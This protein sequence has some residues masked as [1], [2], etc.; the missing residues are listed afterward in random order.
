MGALLDVMNQFLNLNRQSSR[1]KNYSW[2]YILLTHGY[3]KT[4]LKQTSRWTIYFQ[5]QV[6]YTVY[7]NIH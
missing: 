7:N 2:V 6:H 4:R 3:A 1:L 5:K